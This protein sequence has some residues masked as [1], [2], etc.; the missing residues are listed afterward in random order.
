MKINRINI[1]GVHLLLSMPKKLKKPWGQGWAETKLLE[2]KHLSDQKNLPNWRALAC[3]ENLPIKTHLKELATFF[4]FILTPPP[5]PP[6]S[7]TPRVY[8]VFPKITQI[9][10]ISKTCHFFS[11]SPRL[12]FTI[13]I[14]AGLCFL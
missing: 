4:F 7:V 1:A 2:L 10:T 3:Y 14:L 13:Q 9:I 11:Q 12:Q 8:T 5:P 6:K